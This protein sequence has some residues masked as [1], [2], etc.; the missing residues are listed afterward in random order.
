MKLSQLFRLVLPFVCLLEFPAAAYTDRDAN[1]VFTAFNSNFYYQNGTS[2]YFKNTQTAGITYFWGQAEMIES[3]I[4]AYEWNTNATAKLMITNLLNGFMANNNGASW[5]WDGYNDDILWAVLAF[6]RGGRDTGLTNYCNIAKT[7]FDAVYARAWDTNLGGGLYW[8]YPENASKNACVNGPGALAACLL[9]QIYGDPAYLAKATNIYNWERSVLFNTNTGA[10]YDNIG[11]NGAISTWSSTY[12]QGTFLG[13][14]NYLGWTNDAAL[15]AEYTM[16]YLSGGGIL[17]QYGIAGN[18]S[19]F[20]AIFLRW[21]TRFMKDRN[22]QGVYE[23]WL[24]TNA[25]AAWAARRTSDELSWCQWPQTSPAGTNFYAW[26][27]ISSFAALQAATPLEMSSPSSLATDYEGYWPLD[28]TN[29]NTTADLSG[30]GNNG[31][32]TGATVS[33]NGRINGC[34]VF[35]GSNSSVQITNFLCNDFTIA[36]WVKTTQAA[37]TGQWYNGAGLV[38]GDAPG[39][40]NDFGTA[41]CGGKFALGIGN[42]DTTFLSTS[43]I[44]NGVW[45][46]CVAT[47]QQAT[48][49]VHLYVDGVLETT[50]TASRNTQNASSQ[51]LFGAI[52]SGGGYFNGSLDDIQI[53]TRALSSSE[54]ASL[55]NCNISPP[56]GPPANLSAVS[57]NTLVNLTWADGPAATSYNVKRALTSTGPFV[58][59]ANVSTTAFTDTGAANNR[60][61]FYVVSAV[62]AMGESTNSLPVSVNTAPLLA[63]FK[64]DAITNL[65]GGAPV[66][67][68]PDS[69]G[70]SY[71]AF[72]ANISNQPTYIA[73]AING[74]PVVRF[75][76]VNSTFLWFYRPVQDDFTIMFV[77]QCSQGIST[78]TSYWNGAGL[79]NGEQSGTVN[80]FGL[81]INTNGTILAGTGNP[82]TTIHSGSGYTNGRPHVVTFERTKSSGALALYVDGALVASGTAGTQSLTAPNFLA[83]GAQD[84]LNNYLNG[85]I[86]EVQ[87]YNSPLNTAD[88]QAREKELQCKY[89]LSGGATPTAPS[90]LVGTAGNREISLS[91]NLVSGAT[92]YTL[93]RSIDNGATYQLAASGMTAGSYVDTNAVSGIENFYEVAA[94]DDC[95]TGTASYPAGVTL[96]LPSLG[97]NATTGSNSLTLTWPGWANDW[98]LYGTTNLIPPVAW[99]LVTN[100]AASNSGQFNISLPIDSP[101]RFFRLGAP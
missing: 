39:V 2:A 32:V 78:G 84:T 97:M 75:N 91:W 99:T 31:V 8:E 21:M 94:L 77:F 34:L 13:A 47:R 10:I 25:A 18:N 35:N 7:N 88:R 81:S 30:R 4:D 64:A 45:H 60:T 11:T 49:T 55:Y 59:V 62:N 1:T 3:V 96:P 33:T 36:F 69:S 92:S 53:F 71:N 76:G 19:G 23:P 93:W 82:D 73:G 95:G 12:N 26:D 63:W 98:S 56:P 6:A 51:L 46:H 41:M 66:S 28:G 79:V 29:G 5:T 65:P 85:D 57:G 50:G 54:V 48:G 9:Y 70:N 22:L 43:L 40:A 86:A 38:D 68:W 44:N 100:A 58:T 101:M 27:C 67:L 74:L 42:P 14:A 52:A 24:Q 83:L 80:D 87:I 90:G 61:Y 20:N 16:M 15:A 17:P 89:G 72:Q 37:G